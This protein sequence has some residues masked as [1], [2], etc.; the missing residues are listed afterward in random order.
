M[1]LISSLL[2]IQMSLVAQGLFIGP[3]TEVVVS[4]NPNIVLLD[5]SLEQNGTF[6]PAQSSLIVRGDALPADCQ[7]GGNNPLNLFRLVLDK[8]SNHALLDQNMNLSNQLLFVQ[9]NLD[10]QGQEIDLGNS[11]Y[12]SNENGTRR[13]FSS[14]PGGEVVRVANYSA[15]VAADS[16]N[17]G[18]SITSAANLGSTEIRRGHFPQNLPGGSGIERYVDLKPSL[19]TG[20]NATLRMNYF[21]QELNGQ[22]ETELL[23][24]RSE[25]GGTSWSSAGF[26]TRDVAAN[27]LEL[28]GVDGFSLWTAATFATFPVEWLGFEA[29][30]QGETALC[31]WETAS[32]EAVSHF[33]VER[34]PDGQS[35]ERVAEVAATGNSQVAQQ[36]RAVDESPFPGENIYRVKAVDMDGS[37]RY[38]NLQSLWFESSLSVSVFPNPNWGEVKVRL[39]SFEASEVELYLRN[40]QGQLVFQQ[41]V[42]VAGGV[43]EIPLSLETFAEGV[44]LLEVRHAEQVNQFR[45]SRW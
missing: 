10:L 8:S 24:F 35:F 20:L 4:G 1:L 22:T 19:N 32:E 45:L 41:N 40:L 7:L 25:D 5:G 44:Y 37:F 17:L 28:S 43:A 36:Y 14:L 16:G 9:G 15:P 29:I 2:L 3:G 23:F 12:L 6:S 39:T 18:L 42:A 38:S 11:G 31:S 34:S 33:V 26:T 27:Y 13:L 30:Q 21:D